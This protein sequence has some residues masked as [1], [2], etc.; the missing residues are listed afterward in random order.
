MCFKKMQIM[1]RRVQIINNNN[2]DCLFDVR[3][4]LKN[5]QIGPNVLQ[6]LIFRPV[7]VPSEVA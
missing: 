5:S 2:Y 4:T 6:Q 1:H 3:K 7:P